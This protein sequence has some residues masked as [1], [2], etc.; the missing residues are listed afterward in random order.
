MRGLS[1]VITVF[2]IA[3]FAS[4][5][6][7]ALYYKGLLFTTRVDVGLQRVYR[8]EKGS[9]VFYVVLLVVTVDEREPLRVCRVSMVLYDEKGD[10]VVVSGEPRSGRLYSRG[11][12]V[13]VRPVMLVERGELYISVTGPRALLTS[14]LLSLC[15]S[16]GNYAA[17]VSVNVGEDLVVDAP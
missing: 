17:S 4:A 5:L 16:Q 7:A 15:D 2:V 8:I 1:P 12:T 10:R 6:V 14:L 9:H 11:Y 13:E 3:L